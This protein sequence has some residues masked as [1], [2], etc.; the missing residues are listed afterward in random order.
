MVVPWSARGSRVPALRKE[1]KVIGGMERLLL[2]VRMDVG[3]LLWKKKPSNR[4]ESPNKIIGERVSSRPTRFVCVMLHE[5]G[6]IISDI[7]FS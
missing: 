3:L 1:I 7:Y 4:F 6:K 5:R 2:I